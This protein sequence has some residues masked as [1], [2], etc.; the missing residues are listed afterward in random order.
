[1]ILP[2]ERNETEGRMHNEPDTGLTRPI[3]PKDWIAP[4]QGATLAG[5]AS[6][7]AIA[8]WE[9]G[10]HIELA[11]S[12]VTL[13]RSPDADI[14]IIGEPSV[15]RRH[16]KIIRG[17][18]GDNVCYQIIDLGSMNG[19]R[20]NNQPT[21]SAAL[22]PGDKIQLG[23]V[24]FKFVVRDPLETEFHKEVH[25]RIHYDQLTGL[26][27]FH[28]F[29]KHLDT[30]IK[31]TKSDDCFSLAM[32]DLDG[33]KRVNDTHG[34]LAGRA[35]IRE[36][37]A[38]MRAVLRPEDLA[39]LYG[40]DEAILLFPHTPLV[41][42]QAIAERLRKAFEDRRFE[43]QGSTVLVTISQGIAEWPR[44][45]RTAEQIIAAA[46]GAL[47]AAKADGRNCVRIAEP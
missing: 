46:D 24:V 34:H 28:S 27:M 16:A 29:L 33:L 7:V 30:H 40:G 47:Y 10:R 11:Q 5:R 45:G 17:Q 43:F 20:V 42:A 19:T 31:Q 12:E 44:H 32:T 39:A 4:S 37:G 8:G 22:Q 26:L 2:V 9:I 15:S 41:E 25:Q 18:A 36:M 38:I 3:A 23:D 6:L 14:P 21:A 35:V 13:G 1:M